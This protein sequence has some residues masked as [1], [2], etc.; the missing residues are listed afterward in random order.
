MAITDALKEWGVSVERSADGRV[1]VCY[2]PDAVTALRQAPLSSRPE[3]TQIYRLTYYSTATPATLAQ[4]ESTLDD[5]LS[6]ALSRNSRLNVSGA[7]LALDGR[8]LQAL[9]GEKAA[10]LEVFGSIATDGRH[11]GVHIL[12]S[13]PVSGRMFPKWA[14]CARQAARQDGVGCALSRE[15]FSPEKLSPEGA[16]DLLL[17]LAGSE[18]S[19]LHLP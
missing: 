13:R 10:V 16:L 12:E 18:E 7:V 6:T 14:L 9:E 5:I 8:F 3:P 2:A 11:T 1:C 17:L 19:A 4:L 15:P